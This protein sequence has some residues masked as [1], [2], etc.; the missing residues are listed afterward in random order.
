MKKL[1]F[2]VLLVGMC[3]CGTT[4]YRIIGDRDGEN[5]HGEFTGSAESAVR[6]AEQLRL[7]NEADKLATNQARAI[8]VAR[9]V[10]LESL[11]QGL[12]AMFSVSPG[13]VNA[14]QGGMLGGGMMLGGS[15]F[16]AA[17][18]MAYAAPIEMNAMG[19]MQQ[20][21]PQGNGGSIGSSR[22]LVKCPP[23]RDREQQTE[24]QR[25][26]CAEEALASE[27]KRRHGH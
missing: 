9:E 19:G 12:P 6:L 1:Q 16:L 15:P 5:I 11:K 14:G 27:V 8:E 7:R 18:Q 21:A 17:A 22:G 4:H 20:S 2:L 10:D 25:L 13:S 3:S 23:D 24:S 26:A